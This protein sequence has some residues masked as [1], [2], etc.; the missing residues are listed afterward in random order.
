MVVQTVRVTHEYMEVVGMLATMCIIKNFK[1]TK[2]FQIDFFFLNQ[3]DFFN[4]IFQQYF[5]EFF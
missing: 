5:I 4:N 2:I 1:F 3:W